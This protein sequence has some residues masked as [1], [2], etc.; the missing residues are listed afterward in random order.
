MCD[1]GASCLCLLIPGRESNRKCANYSF[2]C[3]M[4]P[5][6]SMFS[7]HLSWCLRPLWLNPKAPTLST[8][9]RQDSR[10]LTDQVTC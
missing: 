4:V 10:C 7:L 9:F 8:A 2:I 1:A 5:K 3:T 6:A